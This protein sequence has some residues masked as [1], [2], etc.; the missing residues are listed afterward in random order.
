MGA[1]NGH[2]ESM[3]KIMKNLEYKHKKFVFLGDYVDFGF[4]GV[5]VFLAV[6]ILKVFS[7]FPC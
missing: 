7:P 3:N 6:A 5:Q 2:V 4:W 1:L